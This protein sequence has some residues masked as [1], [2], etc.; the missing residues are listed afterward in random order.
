MKKFICMLVVV[1][2]SWVGLQLQSSSVSEAWRNLISFFSDNEKRQ[3][4]VLTASKAQINLTDYNCNISLYDSNRTVR[5]IANFDGQ[6]PKD[7]NL[8][9]QIKSIKGIDKVSLKWDPSL[10]NYGKYTVICDKDYFVPGIEYTFSIETTSKTTSVA[11]ST[12]LLY[13]HLVKT[14][15]Q[16]SYGQWEEKV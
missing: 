3:S 15:I 11:K 14:I 16:T 8:I 9:L 13:G 6:V 4:I 1:V 10:G 7:V 2:F 12:T 5:A